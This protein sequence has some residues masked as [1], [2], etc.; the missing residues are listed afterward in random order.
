M[1]AMSRILRH[2]CSGGFALR[3]RFGA[4]TLAAIE[5]AVRDCETRHAGE[6]RF[7]VE[8]ALPLGNLWRGQAPR[9]RAIDVFAQL[10]VWDTEHN[11][12]VLIYVLLADRDVEIVAD[13][14]V[15]GGV[16]ATDEWERC[17]RIMEDHFRAGRFREGAIAGIE[18][19]ADVLARHPPGPR[20][21][22]NE[23]P[24]RPVVL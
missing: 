24:D 7:A 1:K 6:I 10:R 12:G 17:C 4:D 20:S 14:G 2:L 13:R 15:A 5:R 8:A 23:L 3:R 22:A 9:E 18:A 11:N 21:R 16:V 19:V